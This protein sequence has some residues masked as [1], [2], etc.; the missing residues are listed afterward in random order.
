MRRPLRGG[1]GGDALQPVR[2]LDNVRAFTSSAGL[3][4]LFDL[5]W[6]PLYVVVC[7]LFHPW[8]GV[9]VLV[10]AVVICSLTLLTEL[11]TRGPNQNATSLAGKRQALAGNA[12]P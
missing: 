10:G 3:S 11:L 1:A 12:A 4:A 5:P 6:I 7:F 2:D 8:M 9:A